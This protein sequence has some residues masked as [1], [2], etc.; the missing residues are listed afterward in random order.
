MR[1]ILAAATA[2]L[3]MLSWPG[4]AA[5]PAKNMRTT[6]AAVC[7]AFSLHDTA[8]ITRSH[9][10]WQGKKAVVLLFIATECPVSNYYS[11]DYSRIANRY[12]DRG[13]L[14][15]GVHCD[16]VVSAADAAQHA[17]DFG[18]KFPVLLDPR[19]KLAAAV[20]AQTTPEAFVLTPAGKVI[21]HGRIDDRFALNGKRRDEPTRRDLEAA[22]DA[23]LAGKT[24]EVQ[25]TKPYGC[26][27]PPLKPQVN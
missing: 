27:L 26:P 2:V 5:E 14:V 12:A 20:G 17:K 15:Y 4:A 8:G 19:Q 25:E 11:P 6:P 13:V 23:V 21:Y 18:I 10:E 16:P 1:L 3:A 7:E 22:I 9:A 24:P